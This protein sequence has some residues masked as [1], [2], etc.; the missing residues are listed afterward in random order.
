MD[1]RITSHFLDK[2]NIPLSTR[3]H[4]ASKSYSIPHKGQQ[5]WIICYCAFVISLTL[6]LLEKYIISEI[7]SEKYIPNSS[8]QTA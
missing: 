4:D 5:G 7:H 1:H 8:T 2:Y 6:C 3:I